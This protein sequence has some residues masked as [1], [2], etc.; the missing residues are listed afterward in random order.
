MQKP[1]LLQGTLDMLI[2]KVL[3]RESTHGFGICQR[4]QQWS[5]DVLSV[6]EGSLYPALYR[7]QDQGWIESEWGVSE[8]NRR[9]KYYRLTKAGRKQLEV[10]KVGWD[11]MCQAI[12][13]VMQESSGKLAMQ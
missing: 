7:L 11:R 3:S 4:I 13:Q 8:N 2:L 9:A 6:G 12:R 5:D 1:D 10:E